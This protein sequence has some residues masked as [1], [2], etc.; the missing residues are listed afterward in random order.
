MIVNVGNCRVDLNEVEAISEVT[1][2]YYEEKGLFWKRI[3]QNWYYTV[4]MKSGKGILSHCLQEELLEEFK[5]YYEN[6]LDTWETLKG[7]DND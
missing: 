7:E 1:G 2:Q 3:H 4:H 6:L 5:T